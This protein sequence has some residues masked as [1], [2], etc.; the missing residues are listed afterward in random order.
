MSLADSYIDSLIA[1]YQSKIDILQ[2][3]KKNPNFGAKKKWGSIDEMMT[4]LNKLPKTPPS[5][6]LTLGQIDDELDII[7]GVKS[8]PPGYQIKP[9][10]MKELMRERKKL[11]EANHE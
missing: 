6:P 9:E 1:E 4:D 2:A 10:R 3:L 8:T 11:M 5:E 7:R